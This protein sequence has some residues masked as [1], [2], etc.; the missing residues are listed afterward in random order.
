MFLKIDLRSDY[1]QIR[2]R[3]GDEWKT[4]KTPEA[5]YEWMVMLFGLSNAPSTFMRLMNKV[6][7]LCRASSWLSI[8]T[9]FLPTVSSEA[10]HL[11]LW[12]VF[13][14]LQAN[15]LYINMKKFNIMT[16]SLIFLWFV[17]CSQ[18]IHVDEESEDNPRLART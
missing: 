4:F 15:E 5:L 16:M 7:K 6:L 8:L 17:I 14:F 11:H 12:D 2:I 9:T 1:H 13:T 18:G 3:S 10:E